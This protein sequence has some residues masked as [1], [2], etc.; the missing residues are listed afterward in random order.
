MKQSQA[1]VRQPLITGTLFPGGDDSGREGLWNLH[2]KKVLSQ[3]THLIPLS[4]KCFRITAMHAET[5]LHRVLVVCQM[6]FSAKHLDIFAFNSYV[7]ILRV[8]EENITSRA[9]AWCLIKCLKLAF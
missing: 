7:Y 3:E 6:I 2:L 4:W 8:L 1:G 9:N 5:S